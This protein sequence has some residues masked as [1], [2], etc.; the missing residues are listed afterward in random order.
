[1]VGLLAGGEMVN[2]TA[3]R[4]RGFFGRPVYNVGDVDIEERNRRWRC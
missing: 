4:R 1:M 2:A 3:Y